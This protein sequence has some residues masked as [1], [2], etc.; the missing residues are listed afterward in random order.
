VADLATERVIVGALRRSAERRGLSIETFGHGWVVRL[1][2][3][4]RRRHVFG[5]DFELNSATTA[6]IAGDKSATFDLLDADGVPAV[7]HRLFLRRDVAPRGVMGNER[8]DMIGFAESNGWDL[9]CKSNAGTG[10]R[11]VYHVVHEAELD[12]AVAKVFAVHHAVALAPFVPVD[13]EYRVVML[14]G[15]AQ[16]VYEKQPGEGEWRHNLGLGGRAVDVEDEATGTALADLADRAMRA[17]GL[18]FGSVDI[19]EVSDVSFV[20]EV[21]AGV[22]M[23]HYGRSSDERRATVDEIYDRAVAAM[24]A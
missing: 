12:E 8:E 10:G 6:K 11:H 23:E 14:D 20:L 9:V 17:V 16:L 1:G 24:F 2:D 3:G 19:V 21:N 22:M 5:Y 4:D 13:G 15:S 18:R 7:E